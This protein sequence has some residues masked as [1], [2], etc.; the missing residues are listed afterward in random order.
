MNP[1]KDPLRRVLLAAGTETYRHGDTFPGGLENLDA[2]PGELMAV[3]ESLGGL[4]YEP[5]PGSGGPFLLDPDVKALRAAM[6]SVARKAQVA[7]VYY[8]GH[9]LEPE[10][11]SYYLLTADSNGNELEDT[12][13]E[14]RQVLTLLLRRE[15]DGPRCRAAPGAGDPGLLLLRCRRHRCAQGVP[16]RMWATRMSG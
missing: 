14:P 15:E 7:I 9:G 1:A 8:T 3:V 12:A 5:E 6:R 4:G 10:K 2:V 11:D 16:A 13:L